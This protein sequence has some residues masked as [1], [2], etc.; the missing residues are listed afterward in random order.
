[1]PTSL[2]ALGND[3]ID[4]TLLEDARFGNGG[5]AANHEDA[6]TPDGAHHLGWWQPKMKAYHFRL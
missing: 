2:G 4:A 1:M 6:C 5:G 3:R